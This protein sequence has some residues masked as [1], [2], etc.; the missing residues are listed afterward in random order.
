MIAHII[1]QRQT[2][3]IARL[4]FLHGSVATSPYHV[5]IF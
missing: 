1:L 3:R 4:R 2:D 5:V